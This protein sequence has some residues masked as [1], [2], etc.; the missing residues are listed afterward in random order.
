MLQSACRRKRKEEVVVTQF[1]SRVHTRYVL[2]ALQHILV[3]SILRAGV[4]LSLVLPLMSMRR[5]QQDR[6]DGMLCV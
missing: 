6:V 1:F 4:G 2:D 5:K 3:D